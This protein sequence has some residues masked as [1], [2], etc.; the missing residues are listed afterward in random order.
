MTSLVGVPLDQKLVRKV[1]YIRQG[2]MQKREG[3]KEG[4]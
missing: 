3:D 4:V 1:V 2:T